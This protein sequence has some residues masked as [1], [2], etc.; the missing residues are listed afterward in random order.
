MLNVP[1]L[2]IVFN[3]PDETKRVFERIAEAKPKKLYIAADGPRLKNESDLEKCKTVRKIILD[4]I[5]WECEVKTLF[6]E[7]NLGCRVAVS[8][9]IDWFFS[10]EE[11]GIILEDDTLADISFFSFCE[12][13]LKKYRNDTRIGMISGDNFG[14]GFKRNI[15]SYYFTR[16]THIWGWATWRRV[17]EGYSVDIPDYTKFREENWLE[18][19]FSEEREIE[20]WKSNFDKVGLQK[21]DTWDF[22]FVYHN[23]KNGRLNIMPAVNLITNI[24]FNSNATHTTGESKYGN[25]KAESM[26]FPLIH[27]EFFIVDSKSSELSRVSFLPPLEQPTLRIDQQ[28]KFL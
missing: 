8:S 1:V 10:Q 14:F 4:K 20:F 27:P 3:R 18:D 5:D 12:E 2:F 22:Q 19:I 23:L 16:Y 15:D 25:L 24:G 21:F 13:L 7:N 6:R 17:W 26:K 9:S 28:Q 11:E